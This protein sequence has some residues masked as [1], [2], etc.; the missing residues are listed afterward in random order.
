MLR[1]ISN[2]CGVRTIR[3]SV[4]IQARSRTAIPPRVE[5]GRVVI[6]DSSD[7]EW[8]SDDEMSVDDELLQEVDVV[9]GETMEHDQIVASFLFTS[10]SILEKQKTLININ[11][12]DV[13][14]K[15]SRSRDKEKTKITTDFKEL[16]RDER[17]VETMFKNLK[18]EKWSKG[19]QK[20]VTQYVQETYDE[21]RKQL[22]ET[23]LM[24]IKLGETD[25]VTDMNRDIYQFELHEEERNA[26]E[27]DAEVND[28]SHLAE[29]DDYGDNDGDEGY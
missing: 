16:S 3:S 13:M 22:E 2:D 1:V 11:Y 10:L 8:D 4:A 25:D 26:A 29:D 24:E 6:E 15:V 14:K 23:T 27:I 28:L 17:A 5:D 7:S 20:G 18:L 19:L 12:D 21:E 9:E